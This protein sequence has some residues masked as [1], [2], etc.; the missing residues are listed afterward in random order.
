MISPPGRIW[1]TPTG[2][3]QTSACG[4]MTKVGHAAYTARTNRCLG[5]KSISQRRRLAK[6]GTCF[7]NKTETSTGFTCCALKGFPPVIGR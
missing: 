6:V 2:T 3:G 5:R 1:R 7:R 4:Y